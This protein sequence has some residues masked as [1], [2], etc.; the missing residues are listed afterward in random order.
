MMKTVETTSNISVTLVCEEGVLVLV[1]TKLLVPAAMLPTMVALFVE[2]KFLA[3]WLED[4]VIVLLTLATRQTVLEINV[5]NTTMVK[6]GTINVT[7]KSI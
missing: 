1:V 6:N 7:T 5:F 3:N 4:L 2:A